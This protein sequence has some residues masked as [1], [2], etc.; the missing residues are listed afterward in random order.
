MGEPIKH[1]H[2]NESRAAIDKAA[3]EIAKV[4]L[5]RDLW[6]S[7]WRVEVEGCV[8]KFKIEGY[9]KYGTAK[10]V[11]RDQRNAELLAEAEAY[12]ASSVPSTKRAGDAPIHRDDE[13][14]S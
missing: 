1:T 11:E 3:A 8:Y 7:S 6:R 14:Y 13:S 4:L 5:D 2:D 9:P 10:R 12:G